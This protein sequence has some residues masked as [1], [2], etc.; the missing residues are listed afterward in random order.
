MAQDIVSSSS[1]YHFH[2]TNPIT[3]EG[4]EILLL[5][6]AMDDER[7]VYGG[8]YSGDSEEEEDASVL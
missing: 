4:Q 2:R 5:P 7:D 1:H 6:V 8:L 3:W